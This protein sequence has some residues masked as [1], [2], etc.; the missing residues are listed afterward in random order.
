MDVFLTYFVIAIIVPLL[1]ITSLWFSCRLHWPQIFRFGKGLRLLMAPQQGESKM[2]NFAAVATIVG[3]NLGT[4]TVAGT[5]LALMTGGAGAIFWMIVVAV[6]GSVIKLCSASLGVF[7]R[8][9]QHHG[10]SI[11][12]PMFYM[13]RGIFSPRLALLYCMFLI[14]ASLTVGNLV[15]VH[16]F[17]APFAENSHFRLPM[18]LLLLL[19]TALILS[20]GL[21]QFARFMSC[22]VPIMGFFYIGA[23]FLGLIFLHR[24]IPEVMREILRSAFGFSAMKGGAVGILFSQTL[25]A[26]ISRGL[27]ATDIGLGL[28][29]IA[30]A[31][32]E[33]R[34]IPLNQHAVNQGMVALI[35]PLFV[36]LICAMTGLLILCAVPELGA[37]PTQICIDTFRKAFHSDYAGWLIPIVIYCFALTTL[38][39]WAWFAEHAFYFI[40]KAHWRFYYKAFFILLMPLG[41]YMHG[42]LPWTLA[43]IC[44]DGLLLTN[45]YAIFKLRRRVISIMA[46]G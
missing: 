6:L 44:I 12:G 4:G 5:A 21:R 32:V 45:L 16:S 37:N 22:I 36:A 38:L 8:E 3:G 42:M 14:G 23:C 24:E 10:R 43:D 28:A 40:R 35:A 25:Q 7:Y 34:R 2:S 39:A 31:N 26:G 1:L 41:A 33:D 20:G 17:V 11:G 27:F 13:A 29:G 30:H 15:Q 9:E 46:N 18:I 19:P